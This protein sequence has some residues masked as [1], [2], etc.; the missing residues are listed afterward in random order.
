MGA[1]LGRVLRDA[2]HEVLWCPSGR[3]S[4]THARAELAGLVPV[5]DL[6]AMSARCDVVISVVPPHAA[7]EVSQN[8][9]AAGFRGLYVDANAISPARAQEVAAVVERAGATFVD[10]GIVG[11]PPT[12][13]GRTW[14]HLSGP[15][16][17]EVAALFG[18]GRLATEVVSASIGDASAVKVAFAAWTKASTALRTAV[19]A[20]ARTA[21]VAEQLEAQWERI[22][23]GF[24]EEGRKRAVSVT[25]KAWRFE[26]E[27]LEIT[28]AFDAQ[29]IPP[30]FHRAAAEL[31]ASL[32]HLKHEDEVDVDA[33][34]TSIVDA[35]ST[36]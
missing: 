7:L 18:S 17:S 20:Y 13:E 11:P 19:L 27:M 10:G 34:V 5:D 30:G 29:G 14:L 33:V 28:A 25:A 21:G 12:T 36:P 6:S 31:Y 23:P 24:W 8:V 1:E 32:A 2:H 26:G 16:A 22:Q 15:K 4:D 35:S 3:S 9:A